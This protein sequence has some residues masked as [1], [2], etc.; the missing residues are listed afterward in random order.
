M[1]IL[2]NMISMLQCGNVLLKYLFSFNE[3]VKCTNILCAKIAIIIIACFIHRTISIITNA[4]QLCLIETNVKYRYVY[5]TAST[6]DE[7]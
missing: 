7:M 2:K 3:A 4:A 1:K 6:A 5:K